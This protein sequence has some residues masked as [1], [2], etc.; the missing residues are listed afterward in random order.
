MDSAYDVVVVGAGAAGLS[1]ARRLKG[2]PLSTLVVEARDRVGGRAHTIVVDG[3]W[4]IDLGCGWLHSADVNPFSKIAAAGGFTLDKSPPPW[5]KQSGLQA[6]SAEEMLAF[7]AAFDNMQHRLAAAAETGIDRPA[8]DLLDPESPFNGA[9]NAFSAA[10]NGAEFDQVS[11]IDYEAFADTGVNWRVVEGY[12]AVAASLA[13]DL[14]IS[15]ET[16]VETIDHSTD[17][18]RLSTSRGEITARAVIMTLPTDIIA[19][20]AVRFVPG[21]PAKVDAAG[22]LPL[23]LADKQL[24]LI[25]GEDD[26]PKD[27]HFFRRLDRAESG[28]YHLRPFGRP[29]IEGYF[30][31]RLAR[32]LEAEGLGAFAAF[33]IEELVELLGSSW[34]TRL[35]PIAATAWASDPWARGGYS[36]ALPGH[37]GDRAVLAAPVDGRL[38]FAGEA[39][40]T[41]G[42]STAHGAYESGVRAADEVLAGLVR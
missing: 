40:S 24:L 33:A 37:A 39:T 28:S 6:V 20:A 41:H 5:M 15:L 32:H 18:I 3:R 35:R 10:Y 19:A 34:R 11:V 1:A 25:D 8:S 14:K 23:G 42:F 17:P 30:G 31:G 4:P 16:V 13:A 21:L 29:L 12:G 26:L 7:R 9:L 36:H 38:F 27:G 22:C 2:A